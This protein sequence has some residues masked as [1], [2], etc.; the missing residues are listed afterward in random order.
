MWMRIAAFL[1]EALPIIIG[2][3]VAVNIL[4]QFNIF[5]RLAGI[6][7]PVIT[8]L[9]GMPK[10]SIVPLLVG[11]IRK[12]VAIGMFIPLELTIK[13]LIVGSVVLSM[14]FPCIATFVV[15]FRELG[16]KDGLKSM[17]IMLLFVFL[18]GTALNFI[19]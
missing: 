12:D 3:V 1:K 9:W 14:F 18:T 19:L 8:R 13:Q 17:G 5:E 10:E 2:A 6:F 11:I 4:Y 16:L 7:E 15:L